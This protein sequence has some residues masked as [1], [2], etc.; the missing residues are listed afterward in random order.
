[1]PDVP[2]VIPSEIATVLNSIGVPPAALMPSL[3]CLASARRWKLHGIVSIHVLATPMIGLRQRLVVVADALQV[4]PR[5]RA[6]AA[7]GECA[8]AMLEV[9]LTVSG[10]GHAPSLC[11]RRTLRSAGS[12]RRP[13]LTLASRRA[14]P[15]HAAASGSG[16]AAG[17]ARGYA[18]P[19]EVRRWRS[20]RS[21]S[22]RPRRQM[23]RWTWRGSTW[24]PGRCMF[25]L[26][27]RRR[28]SPLSAIHLAS[29]SSES[30][31]RA[32]AVGLGLVR[33]LDAVLVEQA[34]GLRQVGH[35]R[36]VRVDQ[37]RVRDAA[38]VLVERLAAPDPDQAQVAVHLPLLLV[39]ARLQELAGALLGAALAAGVVRGDALAR[40]AGLA[41]GRGD[42]PAALEVREHDLPE[43]RD[44]DDRRGAE[45]DGHRGAYCAPPAARGKKMTRPASRGISSNARTIS[46]SRLPDSR[47]HRNRGPHALLE[48]TA[49]LRDEPLLVLAD[50]DVALGDQLLAVPGRMRRNFMRRIM[51]RAPVRPLPVAPGCR[52]AGTADARAR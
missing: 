49:E 2:I 45:G 26:E 36:L 3:T 16:I 29:T 39:D 12:R 25:A 15:G 46:A 41:R 32:R 38:Q 28:S 11:A 48:L 47:L 50:L 20:R 10:G 18:A 35:D 9:E 6:V 17:A 33:E 51:S 22:Q 44:D 7:L 19:L 43:E 34:A 37:V 24:R 21:R 40:G 14:A 5:G 8:R 30:G 1:M 4:R 31:S 42:A 13:R 52:R 23:S 27:I